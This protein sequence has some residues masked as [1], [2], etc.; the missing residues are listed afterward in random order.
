MMARLQPSRPGFEPKGKKK[1]TPPPKPKVI[2]APKE[3]VTPRPI[4][5]VTAGPY[6]DSAVKWNHPAWTVITR[7]GDVV[8]YHRFKTEAEAREFAEAATPNP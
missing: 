6:Q 3:V 1:P 4:I 2:K 7:Q 5:R 8:Q